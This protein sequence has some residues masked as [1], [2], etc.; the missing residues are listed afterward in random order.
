M[1]LMHRSFVAT[2]ATQDD[3]DLVGFAEPSYAEQAGMPFRTWPFSAGGPKPAVPGL[4]LLL[5][6]WQRFYGPKAQSIRK[7]LG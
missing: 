6:Y 7:D 1:S 3:N 4:V 5:E 2:K